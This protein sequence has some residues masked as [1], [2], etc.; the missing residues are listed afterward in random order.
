[1]RTTY[2]VEGI[3]G[4]DAGAWEGLP[5]KSLKAGHVLALHLEGR[6]GILAFKMPELN[7]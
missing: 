6:V 7:A 5:N 3:K 1:M 4:A 2:L